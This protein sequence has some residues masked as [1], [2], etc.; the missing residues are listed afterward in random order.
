LVCNFTANWVYFVAKSLHSGNKYNSDGVEMMAWVQGYRSWGAVLGLRCVTC[1]CWSLA[2]PTESGRLSF[3]YLLKFHILLS[4]VVVAKIACKGHL[5]EV[6]WMFGYSRR[7]VWPSHMSLYSY[8][9]PLG[10]LLGS[11]EGQ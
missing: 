11:D 9:M 10:L 4:L 6:K 8:S 1:N 5:D 3:D 7:H 2:I